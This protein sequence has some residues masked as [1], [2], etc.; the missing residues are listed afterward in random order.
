MREIQRDPRIGA[1]M[2][3]IENQPMQM[4]QG[5]WRLYRR[6]VAPASRANQPGALIGPLLNN[7]FPAGTTSPMATE[8]IGGGL[9]LIR[10]EAYL[11]VGG[12][13]AHFRDSSPGE[14]LDLGYRMSR[15]WSLF[16]V[17]AARCVHHQTD[18]GRDSHAHYQ[19][20]SVRARFAHCRVSA[21]RSLVLSFAQVGLWA[22][23]QT[24]SELGQLRR[25]HLRAGF[26]DALWGRVRGTWSCIGW[27]PA[28]ERF[29]EPHETQAHPG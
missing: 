10:R 21:G 22:A 3:R 16:Y 11:S 17:P 4:P 12:F 27:N 25:G 7:G 1:V 13:A 8:W 26:I 19:Y 24:L 29:P 9:A 14:D 18:H 23:F 6:L 2:G 15:R 5:L 28:A 20:L